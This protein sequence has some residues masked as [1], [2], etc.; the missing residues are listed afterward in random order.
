MHLLEQG[1]A[2]SPYRDRERSVTA[3]PSEELWMQVDE[4]VLDVMGTAR[5]MR[6]LTDD[7]VDPALVERV[8]WAG[9]RASSPGN[10]Q[11]WD[12]L[13]VTSSEIKRRVQHAIVER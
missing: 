7:P 10:S 6:W 13:V 1:Y 12:F 4:A 9:T 5:S 2:T 8:V 3:S 11:A